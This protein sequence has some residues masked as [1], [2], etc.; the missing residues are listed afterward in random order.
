MLGALHMPRQK[1]GSVP[2]LRLHKPSG[3][4]VV[5]LSGQDFYCGPWGTKIALVQ[6]DRHVSEW[7]ARGRRAVVPSDDESVGIVVVQ[8]LAAYKR[9]AQ[10]Y[11]RKN[12]QITNEVAA[13]RSAS[14][15]VK[16]LY[17]R[18]PAS[19]FGPL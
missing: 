13:I 16:K 7:L 12:G 8:L 17:G 14:L 4:A 15:V 18:E 9:F 1:K 19:D 3:K 10:G 11:Y 5:T 2:G 6:Y